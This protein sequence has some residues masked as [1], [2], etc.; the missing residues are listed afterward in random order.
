VYVHQVARRGEDGKPIVP[1]EMVLE[2]Y[3][4]RAVFNVPEVKMLGA[5]KER[6]GATLLVVFNM[7][8]SGEQLGFQNRDRTTVL[9]VDRMSYTL[10]AVVGV[11]PKMANI[12]LGDADSA[13]PQPYLWIDALDRLMPVDAPPEPPGQVWTAPEVHTWT[14]IKVCPR[15]R[16]ALRA[17]HRA[18]NLSGGVQGPLDGQAGLCRLRVAAALG[19]LTHPK[20]RPF[21][22][23]DEDWRLSGIVMAHSDGVRAGIQAT[24]KA[25]A[26]D[27]NIGKGKAD[28]VRAVIVESTVD[29]TRVGRVAKW[30]ATWLGKQ[31]GWVSGRAVHSACSSKDY[32]YL[33]EAL[34]A[35]SEAGQIAVEVSEGRGGLGYRYRAV[36]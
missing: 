17:A 14:E 24:L 33:P 7:A 9:P 31:G 12:L 16:S 22:V 4:R 21:E 20:R 8:W 13:T 28:A 36:K 32:A 29:K 3:N 26:A 35:A 15:A 19:L 5:L 1:R 11:Q 30:A 27:A 34:E 18:F 6:S 25:A 2:Q 10:C 23:T